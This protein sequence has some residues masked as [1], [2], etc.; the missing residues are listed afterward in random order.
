MLDR[1][2]LSRAEESHLNFVVHQKDFSLFE[3]FF[4]AHEVF[5][6]GNDIAAC[7]LDGFHVEGAEFALSGLGI[8]KRVVFG[9]KDLFEL[10]QAIEAAVLPLEAI[11]AAEAIRVGNEMGAV[12]EMAVTAPVSVT[13][14][15]RCG[16]QSP[17]V[18]TAHEGE[19]GVLVRLVAHQ[20]DG[21]LNSYGP[22]D[23]KLHSALFV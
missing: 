3:N 13:R 19:A 12:A 22:A 15:D 10:L 8:P 6:R 1:P 7:P 4:E 14:G 16:A 21:V 17:A 20:F 9:V 2:E 5:F 23:I 18:V 11:E